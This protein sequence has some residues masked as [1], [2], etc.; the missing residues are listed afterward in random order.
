MADS[1]CVTCLADDPESLI[2]MIRDAKM[3]VRDSSNVCASML[4]LGWH[5]DQT[6]HAR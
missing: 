3:K 1:L 5:S 4:L 6:S 2:K